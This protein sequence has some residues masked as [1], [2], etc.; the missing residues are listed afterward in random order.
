MNS[1]PVANKQKSNKSVIIVKPNHLG[2]STDHPSRN[3]LRK[4][5]GS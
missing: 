2:T 4:A 1:Q 3:S 5:T